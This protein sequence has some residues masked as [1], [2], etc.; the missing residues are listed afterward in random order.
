MKFTD[1]R[2]E[3]EINTRQEQDRSH[4]DRTT[5]LQERGFRSHDLRVGVS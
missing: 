4:C 1:P 2:L 3:S 5:A